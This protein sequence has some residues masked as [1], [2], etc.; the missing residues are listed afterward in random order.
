[1]VAKAQLLN[2]NFNY[3]VGSVLAGQGNWGIDTNIGGNPIFVTAASI[4]YPGYPS[5]GIGQE[6]SI[7]TSGQDVANTFTTQTAG[8]VYYSLLVNLS[9]A[10]NRG[11]YFLNLSQPGSSDPYFGLIYATLSGTNFVFGILN[12]Y[13]G[14][15]SSPTFTAT[16]YNLNTT[17]L[18]VVKV[19]VITGQSSL[20]VNP[21]MT[22]EPIDGWISN[23][24]STTM[25]SVNGFNHIIIR[26]GNALY[27]PTLKLDGIRVATSWNSLFPT[28]GLSTP[29][30][31]VLSLSLSGK[32]LSVKNVEN[33][34][35]V[36]IYTTVGAKVH[37]AILENGSIQLYDLSKGMY[38]VRVGNRSSKIVF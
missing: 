26:Q 8:Y 24:S 27:A 6:V 2:E 35:L 13:L 19:N 25:P 10:Q 36:E 3:T 9:A 32:N 37:T 4:T 15:G 31:D 5:S 17:Y 14:T 18:L 16:S 7:T 28:T 33:G 23:S 11:D 21:S 34:S 22:T 29:K 38:I 30:A 12:T 1:M 20:I